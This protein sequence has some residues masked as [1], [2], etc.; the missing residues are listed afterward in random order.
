MAKLLQNVD[1]LLGLDGNVASDEA[2][3][4]VP[5]AFPVEAR[6]AEPGHGVRV[7]PVVGLPPHPPRVVIPPMTCTT[8]AATNFIR[9]CF[10]ARHYWIHVAYRLLLDITPIK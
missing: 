8:N 7:A 6:S 5:R 1:L 9:N 3:R 10:R 2:D 4:H